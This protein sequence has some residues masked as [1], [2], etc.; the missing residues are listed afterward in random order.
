MHDAQMWLIYA[1]LQPSRC[2][3]LAF[4]FPAGWIS[5]DFVTNV[6]HMCVVAIYLVIAWCCTLSKVKCLG[7]FGRVFPVFLNFHVPCCII[8]LG[9]KTAENPIVSTVSPMILLWKQQE[10]VSK[11]QRWGLSAQV[12]VRAGRPGSWT[13][14]E[15]SSGWFTRRKNSASFTM[16]N[17]RMH[18][19]KHNNTSIKIKIKE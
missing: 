14:I 19:K 5:M 6:L 8:F 17:P 7:G 13:A 18:G 12:A 1:K 4:A 15:S 16:N 10:N 11:F 9:P 2:V 3:F